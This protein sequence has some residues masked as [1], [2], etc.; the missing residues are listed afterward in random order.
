LSARYAAKLTEAGVVPPPHGRAHDDRV[1][2]RVIVSNA[3]WML[4]TS[5]LALW[6]VLAHG[7]P[8]RLTAAI[9][10]R[11][12]PDLDMKATKT[13]ATAAVAFPVLWLAEAAIVRWR[14]GWALTALFIAS[15]APAGLLAVRWHERM[16]TLAS[17]IRACLTFRR[18]REAHRDLLHEGLQLRT[19]LLERA[20]HLRGSAVLAQTA[21]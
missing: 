12:H 10:H 9:L 6:G 15:L 7:L 13:L 11:Q 5:P 18:C 17:T 14:G 16:T 3:L 19:R 21:R 4:L 8:Y 20:P 2:T 1:A